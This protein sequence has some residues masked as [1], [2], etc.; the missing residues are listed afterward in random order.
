MTAF[1]ARP[2]RFLCA[3]CTWQSLELGGGLASSAHQWL[4]QRLGTVFARRAAVALGRIAAV[5]LGRC[6]LRPWHLESLG[7]LVKRQA[8]WANGVADGGATGRRRA[9]LR[10]AA[11]DTSALISQKT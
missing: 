1:I 4:L 8:A 7:T 5:A 6:V 9:L 2:P 11:E 10:P 3:L